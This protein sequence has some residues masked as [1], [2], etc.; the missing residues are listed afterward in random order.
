MVF[1]KYPKVYYLPTQK[2]SEVKR[3]QLYNE[4]E[5]TT[6]IGPVLLDQEVEV[7]DIALVEDMLYDSSYGGMQDEAVEHPRII[8]NQG[9]VM[10]SNNKKGINNLIT[11]HV[12]FKC[13]SHIKE[14]LNVLRLNP[15]ASMEHSMMRST[16]DI[17][18]KVL[19]TNVRD[20]IRDH[21][22]SK[23]RDFCLMRLEVNKGRYDHWEREFKAVII[24]SGSRY[25]FKDE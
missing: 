6:T 18:N 23:V 12:H 16:H 22:T 14:L 24:K 4:L 21:L 20:Y 10:M 13:N 17:P 7:V 9:D 25:M 2:V 19:P 1:L 5:F 3:R 15:T 8:N 11:G